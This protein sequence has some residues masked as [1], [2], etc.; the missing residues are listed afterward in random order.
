VN[1]SNVGY[2]LACDADAV[3]V[4]RNNTLPLNDSI[5]L[6]S[7]T[8]QDDGVEPNTVQEADTEGQFIQLVENGTSNFDDGK[9]GGLRSIGG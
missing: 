6:G 1:S 8:V 4:L 3:D 5:E 2:Q 9:L 7:A